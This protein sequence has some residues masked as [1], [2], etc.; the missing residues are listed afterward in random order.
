MSAHPALRPHWSRVGDGFTLDECAASIRFR[1]TLVES[2]LAIVVCSSSLM[3]I[4][5]S[6]NPLPQAAAIV[7]QAWLGVA[8]LIFDGSGFGWMGGWWEVQS[9]VDFYSM[10]GLEVPRKLVE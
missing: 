1:R 2:F 9:V 5:P 4:D 3:V 8:G 6:K 7:G 10:V